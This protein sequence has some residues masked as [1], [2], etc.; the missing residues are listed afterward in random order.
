M[1]QQITD[2]FWAEVGSKIEVL[3][4]ISHFGMVSTTSDLGMHVKIEVTSKET[5]VSSDASLRS[6]MLCVKSLEF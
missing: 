5:K 2:L 6:R 4:C 1:V 3:S